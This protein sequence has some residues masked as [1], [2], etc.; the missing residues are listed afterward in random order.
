MGSNVGEQ[1]CVSPSL[2]PRDSSK[3]LVAVGNTTDHCPQAWLRQLLARV[4]TCAAALPQLAPTMSQRKHKVAT[5]Q[6]DTAQGWQDRPA[7]P[8]EATSAR[9]AFHYTAS[10]CGCSV[11][12]LP[13]AHDLS[14]L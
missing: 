6:P 13:A 10:K 11:S 14:P 2:D 3:S 1:P 8:V 5:L 9:A 12:C 4:R 7:Y